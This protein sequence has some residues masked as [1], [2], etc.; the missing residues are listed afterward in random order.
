MVKILPV[1]SLVGDRVVNLEGEDLGKIEE[2]MLDLERGTVAYAVLSFGGVLGFGD[3]LFAIPWEALQVDEGNNQVLLNV[4]K[5][6]LKEADGFDKYQWPDT[7]DK[8]FDASA[9]KTHELP[10]RP[11][12]V[13]AD[14]APRTAAAR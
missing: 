9:R 3:K 6:E 7:A 11:Q 10:E 5:G 2:V 1:S 14:G 13:I 4:S 12:S 8:A